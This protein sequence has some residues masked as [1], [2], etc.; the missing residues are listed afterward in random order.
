[1][2][3]IHLIPLFSFIF[4]S[5][6][7]NAQNQGSKKNKKKILET[8]KMIK[9]SDRDILICLILRDCSETKDIA[10]ID[11]PEWLPFKDQVEKLI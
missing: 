3:K 11:F 2:D 4:F 5:S 10:K 1:M 8:L 7:I 9:E 6:I